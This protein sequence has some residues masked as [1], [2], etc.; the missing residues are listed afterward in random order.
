[1]EKLST[2]PCDE[3]QLATAAEFLIAKEYTVYGSNELE[4]TCP[5]GWPIEI[6]RS[7]YELDFPERMRMAK[8]F[9]DLWVKKVE[10]DKNGEETKLEFNF[11]KS[12]QRPIKPPLQYPIK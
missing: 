9:I 3:Y 12:P 8:S 10:S 5:V 6:W 7:L 2:L 11:Q 1:M 4:F